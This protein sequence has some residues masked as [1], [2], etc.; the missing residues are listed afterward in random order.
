MHLDL[1]N[2][3]LINRRRKKQDSDK[4]NITAIQKIISL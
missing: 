3:F 1:L 4:I 2:G